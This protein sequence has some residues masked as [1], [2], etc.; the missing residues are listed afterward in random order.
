MT[1]EQVK[2]LKSIFASNKDGSPL[3]FSTTA[4]LNDHNALNNMKDMV[5]WDDEHELVVGVKINEDQHSQTIAPVKI[6]ACSYEI[7]FFIDSLYTTENFEIAVDKMF[8]FLT[9]E[10]RA[11]MKKWAKNLPIQGNKVDRT[12][13]YYGNDI[14]IPQDLNTVNMRSETPKISLSSSNAQTT[15]SSIEEGS[16]VILHDSNIF[17][18]LDITKSGTYKGS[19]TIIGDVVVS[20]EEVV[21]ESI[22]FVGNHTNDDYAIVDDLNMIEVSSSC[23]SITFKNCSFNAGSGLYNAVINA[24]NAATIKIDHCSFDASIG[25]N[26][27]IYAAELKKESYIQNTIFDG[28]IIKNNC[29]QID[30]IEDEAEIVLLANRWKYA[31]NGIGISNKT[32]ATSGAIFVSGNMWSSSSS[33]EDGGL[34][35]IERES[36]SDSIDFKIYFRGNIG[37]TNYSGNAGRLY[38]TKEAGEVKDFSNKLN[39]INQ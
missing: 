9:A 20:A 6:T 16:T 10:Q 29:I 21:F 32:G 17:D 8:S 12:V 35:C 26:Y 39:I 13:P 22:N 5:I 30:G 36:E 18:K 1:K 24:S 34:V 27:Y 37:P 25:S 28:K 23:K 3:S 4:I 2:Y 38:Y 7:L 33:A 19:A 31:H 15:L 11:N 14:T